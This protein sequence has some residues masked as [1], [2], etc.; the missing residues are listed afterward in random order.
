MLLLLA[1]QAALLLLGAAWTA[2]TAG[3]VIP[4]G[5]TPSEAL[6]SGALALGIIYTWPVV[7]LALL[8]VLRWPGL[9]RT[10]GL[11]VLAMTPGRALAVWLGHLL[12]VGTTGVRLADSKLWVLLDP[13]EWAVMIAGVVLC[14]RAWRLAAGA[15]Q[16]LPPETQVAAAHKAWARGLLAVTGVFA[17][18][19]LGCAGTSRYLASAHLLQ[20]G[21]DPRRE[22]E[23]LLAVN[24]GA[25]QA[26]KGDLA[27]ADQSFQRA[28]KVWEE[29]AA[30]RGAPSLYRVNLAET[31]YN[32]GWTREH[33]D[34][35]DEAEAYYARAVTLADELA[36]DPHVDNHFK[37]VMA[38]ARQAL[39]EMRRDR[40]FQLLDEKDRAAFRK[41][42]EAQVKAQKGDI[43]AEA[44]YRE[45]IALWEEVLPQAANQEYRK[46]APARLAT[47]Y[48]QLGKLQQCL[49]KRAAAEVSLQKAIDYGE[50]AVAREPDRPLP[51]HHL[52]VARRALEE[53][54]ELGLEEEATRLSTAG[55]FADAIDLLLRS[56]GK[57]EEQLRSGQ[58]C[59]A[60]ARRLAFR[61]DRYAWALAH[62]PDGRLR[63]PK[64]AVLHARRATELQPDVGDHWYTLAM[65]QYRNG[66]WR[67]SLA[68]LEKL[69]VKEG[70]LDASGWF[71]SAMDLHM[72]KRPDEARAALRKGVEWIEERQR[73]AAG[74]ALLRLQ[75]EMTRPALEALRREAENLIEGKDPT[76]QGVT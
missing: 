44:L 14:A 27:A 43:D 2:R 66:D 35:R 31:L 11:V 74:N 55:R 22:Q 18:G 13:F 29:L 63:D 32:L 25:A 52:D 60:A 42:E 20:P 5:E 28:L 65:V 62:C 3:L 40:S 67:D 9:L 7:L 70:G 12:A 51:R 61:L 1:I 47:A 50:Q 10:A 37:Q 26:N 15:R 6:A 21:V 30:R 68:S 59:G 8:W 73:Q 76:G 41:Y 36:A 16:I 57:S 53:L 34:R 17:L 56:A 46:T 58:D 49:G 23:A 69:K 33:Q 19:F 39:A 72:L 71:L 4:T 38:D 45:A 64:E 75:Y 54:R 24:E 48:L